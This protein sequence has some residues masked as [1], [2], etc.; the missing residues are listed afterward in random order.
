MGNGFTLPIFM[1]FQSDDFGFG[2]GASMFG[3]N[4]RRNGHPHQQQ[5][6][7]CKTVTQKVGNTVTTF[8]HC[9]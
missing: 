4:L 7:R 8:T 2:G 1:P 6:Q 9:S 5:Q 3:E